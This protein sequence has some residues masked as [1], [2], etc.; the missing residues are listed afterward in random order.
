MATGRTIQVQTPGAQPAA[1][2]PVPAESPEV[3]QPAA[4]LPPDLEAVIEKRV[5][6]LLAKQA[7]AEAPK[8]GQAAKERPYAEVEAEY[9]A[10]TP[11][12]RAK[13]GSVLTDRGHFVPAEMGADPKTLEG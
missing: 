2:E 9:A 3:A 10:M 4:E 8:P 5:K 1:P 11:K 12:Q 7:K 6:E 13:A